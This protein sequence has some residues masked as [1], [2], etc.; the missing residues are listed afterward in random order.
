MKGG[1][2]SG[3][4]SAA[5]LTGGARGGALGGA[6]AGVWVAVWGGALGSHLVLGSAL[7]QY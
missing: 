2:W 4:A 3:G 6:W 5:D 1:V 7:V